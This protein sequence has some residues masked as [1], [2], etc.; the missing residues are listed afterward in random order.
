MRLQNDA[1]VCLSQDYWSSQDLYETE[2]GN[3]CGK[4]QFLYL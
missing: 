3:H 2:F 4:T 1:L